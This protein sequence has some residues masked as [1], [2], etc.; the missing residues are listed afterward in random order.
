MLYVFKQR[1]Y[2]KPF[3]NKIVEVSVTK[4]GDEYDVKAIKSPLELNSKEL[5]ELASI[6]L[7]EAYKLQN[8]E[9]KRN[10]LDK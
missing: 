6:T 4:T 8:K 7:E 10:I 3:D 9:S 2:V 5:K 1:I